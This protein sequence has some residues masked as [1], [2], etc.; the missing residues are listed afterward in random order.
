M[1]FFQKNVN[2]FLMIVIVVSVVAYAGSTVYYQETFQNITSDSQTIKTRYSSCQ[3]ELDNTISLL[4]RTRNVLNATES[5]IRK[6][7]TLYEDKSSQLET[8]QADLDQTSTDL[9]RYTS[10]YTQEKKRAEDLNAEVSR[11]TKVKKD[12]TKENN[13]LRLKVADLEDDVESLQ[14]NLEECEAG[15]S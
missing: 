6:Y 2:V 15:G 8:T 1:S 4:S 12:L 14:E 13:A 11:L 9:G 3:A 10:L 7:D 5:D